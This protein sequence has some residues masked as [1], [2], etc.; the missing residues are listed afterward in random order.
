MKLYRYNRNIVIKL[1]R[2][3]YGVYYDFVNER[4]VVKLLLLRV[5]S[6]TME[7]FW[8]QVFLRE[9]SGVLGGGCV[10]GRGCDHGLHRLLCLS[11]QLPPQGVVQGS[12]FQLGTHGRP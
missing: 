8:Q 11:L 6:L 4:K 7:L 10:G 9:T 1:S 12:R 5:N 2:Y 3:G